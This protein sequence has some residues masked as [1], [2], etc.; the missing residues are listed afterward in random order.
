MILFIFFDI[1][2]GL[3]DIMGRV[4]SV[5]SDSQ[6]V[7]TCA[8]VNIDIWGCECILHILH[9]LL[10]SFINE[11]KDLL[12]PIFH[13]ASF[14]ANS[15]N[16]TSFAKKRNVCSVPS[17]TAIRWSSVLL[18][19]QAIKFAKPYIIEFAP[20][21]KKSE[22]AKFIIDYKIINDLL[23]PLMIFKNWL[24]GFEGDEFGSQSDF[25]N[26]W[27]AINNAFQELTNHR[28]DNAK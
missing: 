21:L 5:V 20:T 24:E 6:S 18:S 14:L 9:T 12:S 8:A 19:F 22:Q 15:T 23:K 28:W 17:Y 27:Y 16:W 4:R 3:N 2:L 7:M 10:G 13:L 26:R 25:L 11:A 1:V